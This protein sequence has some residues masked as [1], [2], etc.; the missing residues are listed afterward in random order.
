MSDDAITYATAARY[1]PSKKLAYCG[2]ESML[3]I[4]EPPKDSQR[5]VELEA[6]NAELRR[7]VKCLQ[8]ALASAAGLLMPYARRLNGSR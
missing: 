8:S 2:R 7:Q 6:E 1:Q 4:P 5:V 3:E